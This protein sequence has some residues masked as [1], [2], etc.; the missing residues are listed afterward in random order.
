MENITIVKLPKG[1]TRTGKN[2]YSIKVNCKCGWGT[3]G[4]N[5][6]S[7]DHLIGWANKMAEWHINKEH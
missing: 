1:Q 7:M 6:F 2:K 3:E 4:N 5:T